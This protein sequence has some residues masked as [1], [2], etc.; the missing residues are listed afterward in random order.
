MG[1]PVDRRAVVVAFVAKGQILDVA[2]LWDFQISSGLESGHFEDLRG[3]RGPRRPLQ[4]VGA[5]PPTF[6]KGLRGPRGRPVP[7]NDRLPILRFFSLTKLCLKGS[8]LI[9]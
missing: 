4:K 3:P 1:V 8:Y 9:T 7:Q 5:S 2:V 6:W